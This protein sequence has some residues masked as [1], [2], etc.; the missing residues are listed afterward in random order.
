[1]VFI[2]LIFGLG[3]CHASL[4]HICAA[5]PPAALLIIFKSLVIKTESLS[6]KQTDTVV[7]VCSLAKSFFIMFSSIC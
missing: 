5:V 7:I 4:V 2:S 3:A 1:M 6:R